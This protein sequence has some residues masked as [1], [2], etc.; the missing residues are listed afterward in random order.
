MAQ[1][2][3]NFCKYLIMSHNYSLAFT[4]SLCILSLLCLSQSTMLAQALCNN[5]DF[6]SSPTTGQITSSTSVNGWTVYKMN[7]PSAPGFPN[8]CV[9]FTSTSVPKLNPTA[10]E[11]YTVNNHIDTIIGMGYPIYSV[12]GSGPPNA[13]SSPGINA[14]YG[15]R[16]I[17]VG[18]PNPTSLN[19]HSIEKT[20]SVSSSNCLFRFAYIPVIKKGVSACCD[21]SSVRIGFFNASNNVFLSCPAFSISAPNPAC[22]N[23]DNSDLL[24][25]PTTTDV[26]YHPWKIVAVDL[27][28][29]IGSN[30][31]FKLSTFFCSTGCLK[32]AYAYLDAQCGPMEI[33]VN[34]APFPAHTN[35]VTFSSCS[36]QQATVIA[37]PDFS[38]YQWTGP[39]NFTSTL[40]SITT[41]ASGVYTLNITAAGTCST[42][43]KYVNI[44]LYPAANPSVVSTN[45]LLCKGKPVSIIA[46][47]L[48]TYS[49]TG[50]PI[51]GATITVAPANTTT[52]TVSGVNAFGCQG[53]ASIT[54]SVISCV[55]IDSP[56]APSVWMLFP[57]PTHEEFTL[58]LQRQLPDA[59]IVI[60]DVLGREIETR[61]LKE[62]DNNIRLVKIN[63]GVY[64]YQ[65]K[66]AGHLVG[67]GK[68]IID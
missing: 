4:R 9:A 49:W 42:I 8:N 25:T 27:S 54:Q 57:N 58:R 65:I 66:S 60:R 56:H 3:T 30:I 12:F 23:P 67:D 46:S 15:S 36:V 1:F 33:L 18:G 11:I 28:P 38:T 47:G 48:S 20:I 2:L 19:H 34:G 7:T 5:E 51:N 39:N 64:H 32:F 35:S 68:L 43:T 53:S 52:Y 29:Y 41:S 13:G 24:A 16:F 63:P 50:L 62:G 44:N 26:Y 55:G 6:E 14:L 31:T 10:C 61:Q 40:S 22:F 17:R 59:S 21:L 37:P 45:T